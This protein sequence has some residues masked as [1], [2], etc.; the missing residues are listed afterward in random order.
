[1]P[2]VIA[3]LVVVFGL[4][5]C[6]VYVHLAGRLQKQVCWKSGKLGLELSPHQSN[7]RTHPCTGVWCCPVVE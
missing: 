2:P 6:L 4:L 1:M 7:S 3:E 5:V